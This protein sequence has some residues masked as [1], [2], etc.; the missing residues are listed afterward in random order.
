MA[1]TPGQTV[2]R[3]QRALVIGRM[4]VLEALR[5]GKREPAALHYLRGAKGLNAILNAAGDIPARACERR[6]LDRLAK[7]EVHQGAVLEAEPLPVEKGD[8]WAQ[9]PFPETA[10][11]AVLDGV[12]DPHNFGAIVRSAA[13]CGAD[14]VVF[15]QDRAAP[16][17]PTAVKSAAGAM[18]Y[19]TLVEA[20]N[21]VRCVQRMREAGFW[22]TGLDAQ[23]PTLIWDTDL[24]GRTGVVIGSEGKG[25]R[26][27]VRAA[28]D[29]LARI[30]LEGPITSLNASVSAAIAFAE[31]M[32]QR[33]GRGGAE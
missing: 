6:E 24:T 12:E 16:L 15:A 31:S 5:A 29:A 7:G 8:A 22:M 3:R 2:N 14:A 20:A 26:R 18:E 27:L 23:G 32:R 11:A 13:A 1:K 9:G 33:R 21:L 28:C 19:V 25:M 10:M 17:S 30:P 4:P